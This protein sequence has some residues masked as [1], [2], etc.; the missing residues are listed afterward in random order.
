MLSDA[1]LATKRFGTPLPMS[2]LWI[3]ASYQ[4]AP[5]CI[6]SALAPAHQQGQAE[7]GK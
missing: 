5:W 7:Q 6:V 4:A 3:L 2:G 1:L